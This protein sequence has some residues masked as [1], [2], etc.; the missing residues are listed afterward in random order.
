LQDGSK[1]AAKNIKKNSL[2]DQQAIDDV[3]REV[4]ILKALKG[5]ANTVEFFGAFET[6]T[7]VIMVLEYALLLLRSLEISSTDGV[8]LPHLPRV[9]VCEGAWLFA[10]LGAVLT[11]MMHVF[12]AD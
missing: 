8:V 3:I 4:Q 11:S 12:K 10:L 9:R 7:E 5:G 6:E 2:T 1:Y